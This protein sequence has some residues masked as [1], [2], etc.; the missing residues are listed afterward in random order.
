MA[1]DELRRLERLAP[2]DPVAAER[3]A[4]ARARAG[5]TPPADVVAARLAAA[6]GALTELEGLARA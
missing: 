3:L 1:D 4:A 2:T 5:R 6:G